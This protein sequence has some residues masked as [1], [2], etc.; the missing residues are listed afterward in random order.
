MAHQSRYDTLKQ[1]T[2]TLF[3]TFAALL[4]MQTLRAIRLP[5]AAENI[6]GS[7]SPV[8]VWIDN[9][10]GPAG[11]VA[12]VTIGV[13]LS[14]VLITR[15]IGRYSLSVVRSFVPMA[16][17]TI[18]SYGVLYPID[19]PSM[20]FAVAMIIHA[21]DLMIMSFKRSERFG[22]VMSATLWT[23][24]SAL[25]IPDLVY[26]LAL[27]PIQWFIW[28]RSPR[29]MIAA[30]LTLLT[31][32][33]IATCLYWFRGEEFGWFFGEWSGAL[34]HIDLIDLESLYKALGGTIGTALFGLL[35]LI[36]GVSIVVFLGM[37]RGMRLRARKGH[38]Y[39]SLLLLV[40]VAMLLMNI[41]LAIAIPIMGVASVPLIH[42]LFVRHKGL[43][44]VL[45][46]I[47]MVT[48][49]TL[50]ALLPLYA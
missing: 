8:G 46:Y 39:F 6:G 41:P 5:L 11:E 34:T 4:T 9:L 47:L 31:P 28:Q 3:V 48:L 10:M 26:L 23:S 30:L 7:L 24:L 22:E 32:P 29:E 37:Q 14:A 43:I 13:L 44:S 21:T 50:S 2:L 38:I 16:L 27:L 12:V 18:C 40:G 42:T 15:I 25:L 33:F 19:S 35:V 36:S 20:V 45:V 1:P 49:A 17:L